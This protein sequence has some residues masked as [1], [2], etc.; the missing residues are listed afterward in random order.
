MF[1]FNEVLIVIKLNIIYL[2]LLR[3][4]LFQDFEALDWFLDFCYGAPA[5]EE[6]VVYRCKEVSEDN[7]NDLLKEF[8]IPYTHI[9]SQVPDSDKLTE[10]SK[11]RIASY[12]TKL[13]T[14]LW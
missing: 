10:E 13:D 3:L 1:I 5:P 9:R 14:L 11:A 4:L 8:E 6:T 12:E 2:D 7:V